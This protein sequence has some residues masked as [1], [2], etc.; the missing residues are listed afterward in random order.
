M[1]RSIRCR[2][3]RPS[4][5]KWQSFVFKPDGDQL[6]PPLN[7]A[8]RAKALKAMAEKSKKNQPSITKAK[9]LLDQLKK[10]QATGKT[11]KKELEGE[12]DE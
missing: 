9:G 1:I 3:P 4:A 2:V 12:A 6:V 10:A 11:A 8:E 7:P 5:I